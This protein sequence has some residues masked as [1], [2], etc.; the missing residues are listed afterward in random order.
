V[1]EREEKRTYNLLARIDAI[2]TH[3]GEGIVVLRLIFVGDLEGSGL[4][5]RGEDKHVLELSLV[6]IVGKA[7]DKD[8]GNVVGYGTIE[9]EISGGRV[10][11][12]IETGAERGLCGGGGGGA[13]GV[14]GGG[15]V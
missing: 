1:C 6:H 9:G 10:G 3:G 4:E 2:E 12:A 7:Y 14:D 13:K 8:G 15:G 5:A 11:V